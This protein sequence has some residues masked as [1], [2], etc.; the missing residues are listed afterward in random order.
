VP[1]KGVDAT[2]Q[3]GYDSR[4]G[5][6][7]LMPGLRSRVSSELTSESHGRAWAARVPLIGIVDNDSDRQTLG[8][9][10][11]THNLVVQRTIRND[12]AE[13]PAEH[14]LGLA[15]PGAAPP[16]KREVVGNPP[17]DRYRA[18]KLVLHRR[19]EPSTEPLEASRCPAAIPVGDP[20]P[21]SMSSSP[22]S[23]KELAAPSHTRIHQTASCVTRR[24]LPR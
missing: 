5:R 16:T 2:L 15:R 10:A 17:R 6:E 8:S 22:N 24:P 14:L 19:R 23:G 18:D 9:L 12:A 7:E 20:A 21:S 1:A 3:H 4:G 13:P 11:E